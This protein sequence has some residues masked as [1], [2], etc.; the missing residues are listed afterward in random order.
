M[1]FIINT[2]TTAIPTDKEVSYLFSKFYCYFYQMY[3]FLPF[4]KSYTCVNKILFKSYYRAL[5]V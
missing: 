3:T 2:S 1:M 4:N 5:L